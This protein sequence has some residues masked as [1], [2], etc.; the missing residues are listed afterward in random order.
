MA[1]ETPRVLL[2]DDD[3]AY[4]TIMRELLVRHGFRVLVARAAEEALRMLRQER[5][6]II[7]TDIM[8]PEVDGLTLIRRIRSNPVGAAIPTVV[9][10]AL[11]MARN[12]AAAAQ[13]GADAFLAKPF[14]F[15]QLRTTIQDILAV[16]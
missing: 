12:R 6:D 13:A 15:N 4:C 14:S 1:E 10:S 16:G 9:V 7:L 2:V 5:P 3:D 8:M 11:V